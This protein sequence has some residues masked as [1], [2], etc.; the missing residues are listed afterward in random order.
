MFSD[1]NSFSQ[2]FFGDADVNVDV[3]FNM[4]NQM[5]GGQGTVSQPIIEPMQERVV[6]R[7]IMHEVPQVW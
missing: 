3:D 4:S 1:T 6:N 2:N 5:M 7:T